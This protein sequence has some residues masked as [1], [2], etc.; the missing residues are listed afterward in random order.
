MNYLK[1]LAIALLVSLSFV[2]TAPYAANIEGICWVSADDVAIMRQVVAE[3]DDVQRFPDRVQTCK[4]L[5]VSFELNQLIKDIITFQRIESFR[6][7]IPRLHYDE[8]SESG[9]LHRNTQLSI[10]LMEAFRQKRKELC[11]VLLKRDFELRLTSFAF[12]PWFFSNVPPLPVADLIDLATR[13]EGHM[14]DISG[15]SVAMTDCRH[16]D[17]AM[18]MLELSSHCAA[19]SQQFRSV[20]N[21]QPR[22]LLRAVLLND[23]LDDANMVK[24]INHCVALGMKIKEKHFESIQFFHPEY[25]QTLQTIRNFIDFKEDIK[26]PGCD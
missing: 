8:G 7:L 6:F 1:V 22:D 15:D 5:H 24:V 4:Q 12:G 17:V 2:S 23:F 11:D 13:H 10:Y 14:K 9:L 25:S 18:A 20:K 19:I 26:E 16:V 21:H 3:G